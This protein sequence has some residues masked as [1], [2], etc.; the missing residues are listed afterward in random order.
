MI[1]RDGRRVE[2]NLG[3]RKTFQASLLHAAGSGGTLRAGESWVSLAKIAVTRRIP[4]ETRKPG[5]TR[6]YPRY[7]Q[8]CEYC[9]KRY[10]TANPTL[11]RFC[12]ATCRKRNHR[13]N[14][15]LRA[16]QGALVRV[17]QVVQASP[18]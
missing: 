3:P 15:A 1:L 7:E 2:H 12:G 11:A 9:G 8:D 17:P 6:Q 10:L 4:R 18:R 14:Q 5:P 16:Q 13:Q